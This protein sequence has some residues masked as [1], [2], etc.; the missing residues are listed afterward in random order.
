MRVSQGFAGDTELGIEQFAACGEG[1]VKGYSAVGYEQGRTGEIRV[2]FGEGVAQTLF[3]LGL[4]FA[5]PFGGWSSGA[6][7]GPYVTVQPVVFNQSRAICTTSA[8][9]R[10]VKGFP[11][12]DDVDV[13]SGKVSNIARCQYEIMHKGCT[14]N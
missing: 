14:G 7:S 8:S 5:G 2:K 1:S 6:M 12:V 10:V 3:Q 9:V 13:Q 11:R 4:V